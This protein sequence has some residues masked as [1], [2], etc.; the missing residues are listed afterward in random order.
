[1][2]LV[3]YTFILRCY[4]GSVEIS[5]IDHIILSNIF[6]FFLSLSREN[7]ILMPQNLFIAETL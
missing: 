4:I 5:I 6:D 2:L 3:C 7:E 1:M